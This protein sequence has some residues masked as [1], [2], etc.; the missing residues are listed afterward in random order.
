MNTETFETVKLL[1]GG[2]LKNERIV[3][4]ACIF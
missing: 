1:R 2:L 4:N 3:K